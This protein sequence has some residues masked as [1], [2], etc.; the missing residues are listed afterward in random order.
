MA[1]RRFT[2]RD[3]TELAW[4]ETGAGRPLIFLPGF[5]GQGSRLLDYG[6]ARALAARGHRVLAPDSRGSGDSAATNGSPRFSPDVLADDGF[7]L[8]AHLGLGDGDYDLAGYSL[9]A[10]IVV[11]MLAR[12]ARPGRAIVAGQGLAK[13]SGP[14]QGGANHRALTAIVD[15]ATIEP[16]SPEARQAQMISRTGGD[17]RAMLGVLDSLVPTPEPALRRIDV[18]TLVA[19]GDRD[20]RD[21]AD[22]LAA[23][24]PHARFV[25]VPGDHGSALAAPELAA[26][27]VAF[28]AGG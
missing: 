1:T 22:Q 20:E 26:E 5:G 28:L 9:G 13:I 7:A 21:D 27:M 25:R 17:P 23:L 16:D 10:R 24:L 11:R 2:G 6:P 19:I 14:Q 8:I 12:G 3:G 4:H 18:P 15:G